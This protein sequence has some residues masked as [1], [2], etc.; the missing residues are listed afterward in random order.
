M[1]TYD[2]QPLPGQLCQTYKGYDPVFPMTD[3]PESL[4]AHPLA[5]GEIIIVTKVVY[6]EN[7]SSFYIEFLRDNRLY[8]T[9]FYEQVIA[10]DF[11]EN[12]SVVEIE[13][14]L[15]TFD[16]PWVLCER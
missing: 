8:Y 16:F 2:Y 3:C 1:E 5:E 6:H 15:S 9:Y 10:Y 11:N 4:V 12:G 7:M 13:D 14:K